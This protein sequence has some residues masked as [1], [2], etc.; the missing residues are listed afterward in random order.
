MNKNTILETAINGLQ[1]SN[2]FKTESTETLLISIEKGTTFPTHTSPKET[3]LVVLEGSINFYIE[4][5]NI[6]LEK[7]QV[8]TFSK[9]VAHYVTANKNSKFLIIR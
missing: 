9:E 1:V 4:E 2:I 7:Q 8:Y 6:L 3:L 5:D